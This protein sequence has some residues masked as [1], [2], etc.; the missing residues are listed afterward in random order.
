MIPR[1][2]GTGRTT[3][4]SRLNGA[5][6]E[7]GCQSVGGTEPPLHTHTHT[8]TAS[9]SSPADNKNTDGAPPRNASAGPRSVHVRTQRWGGGGVGVGWGVHSAM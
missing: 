9:R 3:V 6:A 4:G 7:R 8:C 5:K 2:A 1:Q